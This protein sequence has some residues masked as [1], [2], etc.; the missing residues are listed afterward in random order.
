MFALL[1]CLALGACGGSGGRSNSN[2]T[3]T[4]SIS[5]NGSSIAPGSSQQFN[6]TVTGAS[7]QSVT[8][9]ASAGT[10]TSAGLFTAPTTSGTYTVTATSVASPTAS[11][12]V[13]VIVGTSTGVHVTISPTGPTVAFG[14][15]VQFTATVT[16]TSNTAVIW[17]ASE[18]TITQT[19]LFT[20]PSAVES[21][22]VTASS[23]ADTT[24]FARATVS[25]V[26][27]GVNV[28][29]SPTG[30]T[31]GIGES[32]A[33]TATVTGATN[34]TVTWSA[35]GGTITSNGIYTA[36]NTAGLYT[37]TATSNADTTKSASVTVTVNPIT[38]TVT[39]ATGQVLTGRTYQL[40]ATVSGTTN[41]AVT[42]STSAGSITTTGLLTAPSA[43]QTVTVTATSQ[44]NS[45]VSGTASVSVV[46]ATD[47]LYN[48]E[49][50][51]PSV[52]SPTT[53]STTPNGATKYLGQFGT[54][55]SAVL[56]LTNL[57]PH[58]T[59][60]IEFDLYVIG[61][62]QGLATNGNFAVSTTSTLGTTSLF[63]QTF[64]NITGDTQTYP[65]GTSNA[66]GTGATATNS[67][68]FI[69]PTPILY[70]DATYHV[71]LTS[72]DTS[73][74]MTVTFASIL[75]DVIGNMSWGIDNVHIH[76]NP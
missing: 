25:V 7:D 29:I 3:V 15:Q 6:A 71:S 27:T 72:S 53:V 20:A 10:I 32:Q 41:K 42:W 16:G 40:N 54:T 38:V 61:G 17:T 24:V 50:G 19:G 64:S 66:P 31:L 47:L 59:V 67:L 13:N 56:S 4:V 39:P 70:N 9:S 34:T 65:S 33:F 26:R 48:F 28:T 73:T 37:V 69:N 35:S 49:S 36:P 52:W 63:S 76:A 62:W 55:N 57:S 30:A 12:T 8:W 60:L 68:G 23:A 43:V 5:P 51:A 44:A 14:Q 1:L 75:T 22:S 58:Q 46:I 18:G 2:P 74:N 45:T 21:V 11:A